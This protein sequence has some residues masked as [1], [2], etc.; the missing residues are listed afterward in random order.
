MVEQVF[1]LGSLSVAQ[2]TEA[3]L[4]LVETHATRV[5]D[6]TGT[7]N[8][9]N[10]VFGGVDLQFDRK[11]S[12]DRQVRYANPHLIH[13]TTT[14]WVQRTTVTRTEPFRNECIPEL[15]YQYYGLAGRGEAN[16]SAAMEEFSKV[17]LNLIALSCNAVSGFSNKS[18]IC[19]NK[20]SMIVF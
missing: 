2:R 6:G 17:P 20:M 11:K 18:Y 13:G 7:R 14:E 16:I 8:I 15:I 3:A 12:L 9:P 19:A 10:F 5:V 1:K 4:W